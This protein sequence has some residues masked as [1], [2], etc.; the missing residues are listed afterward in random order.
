MGTVRPSSVDEA[1]ALAAIGDLDEPA[2]RMSTAAE[3]AAAAAAKL[4]QAAAR[5]ERVTRRAESDVEI[6]RI[7]P[8]AAPIMDPIAIPDL[9]PPRLKSPL[10]SVFGAVILLG[11]LGGA[12][13]LVYTKMEEDKAVSAQ[14]KL[15][16]DKRAQEQ[17][18]I[19][20]KLRAAQPDPGA[21]EITSPGAGIWMRLGRTPLTTPV[22][23]PAGQPHDLVLLREGSHVTEAQV[24]GTHWKGA[25]KS[26]KAKLE[27]ALKPA[28][29][30]VLPVLPL[31]PTTTVLASTG[32]VGAGPVD[33]AST[34][35]DAEVWLFVGANRAYFADLW[36]GRDYEFRVVK[37]GF[38]SQSVVFKADDWRDGGDHRMPIDAAKKKAV[39]SK[40]V[41]L[42][43]DPDAKTKKGK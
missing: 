3:Q 18:E 21:V 30:K 33:I 25:D 41:E 24:N 32:V 29:N 20:A 26:L 2:R 13:Y 42:E 27:V 9:P 10:R 22:H 14:R 8:R 12:G 4:E 43:P 36:A 15:E 28:S 34:P 5:A 1:A 19:E 37:P 6:P 39:L 7:P 16:G 40:A 23:L 35:S 31:Q 38:K 17:A 11:I